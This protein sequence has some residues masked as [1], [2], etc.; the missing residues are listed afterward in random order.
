VTP[1]HEL[2]GL[3]ND[4]LL[5]FLAL[6]G[7]LRALERS[8]PHWFPRAAFCGMPLRATLH[9]ETNVSEE[10]LAIAVAEGCAAFVNAFEFG[11]HHDLTFDRAAARSLLQNAHDVD[12]ALVM[13]ALCSDIA[14]RDDGRILPTPLCAMFGQGH[15]SFLDRLTTVARGTLP[16]E[17]RMKKN[18]PNLNDPSFISR[19]L[20]APWE[21]KDYTESFRWDFR[22]D[23]RY[24][25]RDLDPSSDP[26][27]TEHGANRLAI[28][29]LLSFQCAPIVVPRSNRVD[30][31]TRGFS[32]GSRDRRQRVTWP[33]WKLPATRRAIETMMDQP[34]LAQDVPSFDT[35]EPFSIQ[36]LRRVTRLVNGKFI[37]F[38]R[39]EAITPS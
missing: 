33:I 10:D 18:P 5:G 37:N 15:Q 39:A 7:V 38:G 13:S 14:V 3:E 19:A 2:I 9:L 6:L 29:G 30:L 20:F 35:L 32:R 4:N 24:A 34:A 8:R 23:R 28:L 12:S 16:R 1:Q 31:A 11:E 25:L 21:R 22:E 36:Q 17:L 26:P 27:T